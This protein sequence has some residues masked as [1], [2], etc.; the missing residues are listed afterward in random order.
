M[1]FRW[2]NRVKAIH[3]A[4]KL[5]QETGAKPEEVCDLILCGRDSDSYCKYVEAMTKVQFQRYVKDVAD[6]LALTA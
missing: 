2:V 1:K 3:D 4:Y 5:A 6:L